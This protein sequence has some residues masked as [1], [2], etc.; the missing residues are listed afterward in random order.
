MDVTSSVHASSVS[1]SLPVPVQRARRSRRK[2]D[3]NSSTNPVTGGN[4]EENNNS[5]NSSSVRNSSAPANMVKNEAKSAVPSQ[6][7]NRMRKVAKGKPLFSP[8]S[9]NEITSIFNPSASPS[10]GNAENTSVPPK[11]AKTKKK[12]KAEKKQ[13]LSTPSASADDAQVLLNVRGQGKGHSRL[14]RKDPDKKNKYK[15]TL[16]SILSGNDLEVQ[17]K[18]VQEENPNVVCLL[19]TNVNRLRENL[20]NL[21]REKKYECSICNDPIHKTGKVWSCGSCYGIDHVACLRGWIEMSRK[22]ENEGTE[23]TCPRCRGKCNKMPENICFCGKVKNPSLDPF[24]LLQSCGEVCGKRLANCSHQCTLPCHPGP[25][26]PCAAMAAPDTCWCGKKEIRFLCGTSAADKASHLS[27]NNPCSKQLNCGNP[28]HTCTLTCH[29]GPCPPCS[30]LSTQS[31]YCLK[32]AEER[33]C[34]TGHEA[35]VSRLISHP[36]PPLPKP[37]YEHATLE[38]NGAPV[39][40]FRP[41]AQLFHKTSLMETAVRLVSPED[42]RALFSLIQDAE[43]F[44]ES[45]LGTLRDLVQSTRTKFTLQANPVLSQALSNN[46]AASQNT[47]TQPDG[48]LRGH[49]S[50]KRICNAVLPCGIHRCTELCHPGDCQD[51]LRSPS[52][53]TRCACGKEASLECLSRGSCTDPIPSCGAICEKRLPCGHLCTEICHDSP[54]PP[55]RQTISVTCP[56]GLSSARPEKLACAE[57]YRIVALNLNLK[58][59]FSARHKEAFAAHSRGEKL[60]PRSAAIAPLSHEEAQLAVLDLHALLRHPH[61]LVKNMLVCS[62]ACNKSLDCGRHRCRR[63][64]CILRKDHSNDLDSAIHQSELEAANQVRVDLL[65]S[66]HE[67]RQKMHSVFPRQWKKPSSPQELTLLQLHSGALPEFEQGPGHLCLHICNRPLTCGSHKCDVTCHSGKC[68]PCGII[69][70]HG[71]ICPCGA[72]FTPGPIPCGTQ[73]NP[74]PRPCERIRACGHEDGHTCHE[75]ECPPCRVKTKVS[76]MCGKTIVSAVCGTEVQYSCKSE[77]LKSMFCGHTCHKLCHAGSCVNGQLIEQWGIHQQRHENQATMFSENIMS[78][79]YE[80]VQEILLHLRSSGETCVHYLRSYLI[81]ISDPFPTTRLYFDAFQI[82]RNEESEVDYIRKMSE[83]AISRWKL[84]SERQRISIYVDTLL[85]GTF[86]E[87]AKVFA[88][89]FLYRWISSC[90]LQGNI[91]Q[92]LLAALDVDRQSVIPANL[93]LGTMLRRFLMHA[94]EYYNVLFPMESTANCGAKCGKVNPVCGHACTAT[95]HPGTSCLYFT[96]SGLVPIYCKCGR[97]ASSIPCLEYREQMGMFEQAP[98]FPCDD[99]CALFEKKIQW[100]KILKPELVENLESE[101]ELFATYH[102]SSLVNY[103]DALPGFLYNVEMHLRDF[104]MSATGAALKEKLQSGPSTSS[105]RVEDGGNALVFP[106]M[107]SFHRGPL[108]ELAMYY[109]FESFSTGQD[110]QRY[111]TVKKK[112]AVYTRENIPLPQHFTEAYFSGNSNLV[113][114]P[115]VKYASG[116]VLDG[117]GTYIYPSNPVCKKK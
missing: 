71:V 94:R 68:P 61:N 21:I 88:H 77:C 31:C 9:D 82:P 22:D 102:P 79:F 33:L 15:E 69:N 60:S 54:C 117:L 12:R 34:G 93:P 67:F 75:G 107:R 97:L 89:Y 114:N 37:F 87:R 72:T 10:T 103:S 62:T 76:C 105:P 66:Y 74:C 96:C 50:C 73:P 78:Y 80:K 59:F 29:S 2:N 83:V 32:S 18:K 23:W 58:D 81:S 41:D 30:V 111:V 112:R 64:C 90:I 70:R 57:M 16:A 108:H 26:P 40:I 104:A 46:T 45:D 44:S 13:H 65:M 49:Y 84:L 43:H 109:G 11:S 55:C 6:V 39:R 85:S 116:K 47:R 92:T 17:L 91:E 25:C 115:I 101:R 106:P 42:E 4:T 19:S 20:V 99:V 1:T 53:V 8:T 52:Y 95:C 24:T 56:C 5:A 113:N 86:E 110:P 14:R 98:T 35:S 38:K 7:L 48:R 51:C 63:A 27:C 100:A 36:V 28:F 3:S